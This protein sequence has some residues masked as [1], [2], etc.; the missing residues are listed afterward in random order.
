MK[1]HL[2]LIFAWIFTAIS[3]TI[4]G[5]SGFDL[6]LGILGNT[7]SHDSHHVNYNVNYG[8]TGLLDWWF[9]SK[10]D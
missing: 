6:P 7:K 10:K 4:S 9:G 1:S 8:A 2:A 5:H 3:T